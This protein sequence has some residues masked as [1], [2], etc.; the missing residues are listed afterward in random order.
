MILPFFGVSVI[1]VTFWFFPCLGL[2]VSLGFAVDF[3][4]S[5]HIIRMKNAT[6]MAH[7]LRH[8]V[9]LLL[10]GA[11]IPF[12]LLPRGLG[13]VFRLLPFGSLA[14][15]PLSIFVGSSLPF[16]CIPLQI[17]WNLALWPAAV[18]AFAAS[19]ERMVSYGG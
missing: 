17:F 7:T 8:A 13:G 5:C 12:D 16:E 1:P 10:S 9:T 15:A 11:V 18:F 4:F 19:R 14:A 6:W 2:S 3:I